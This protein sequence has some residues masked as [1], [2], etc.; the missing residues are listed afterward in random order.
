MMTEQVEPDAFEPPPHHK[1]KPSIET[2][3]EALLKE[4]TSQFAQDETFISMTPLI[5]M[6]IDT[7]TSEP[8]SQQVECLAALCRAYV[9]VLFGGQ[10][11]SYVQTTL[12]VFLCC[13]ATGG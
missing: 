10:S 11:S 3:P 9:E 5:E 8:V 6:T 2:K 12:L 7:E 1:L 4:Y 13:E